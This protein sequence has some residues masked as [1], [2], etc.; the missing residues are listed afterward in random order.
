MK[1]TCAEDI[2]NLTEYQLDVFKDVFATKA[3]FKR[4]EEKVDSLTNA[5][6]SFAKEALKNSQEITAL[7]YRI[8]NLEK[9]LKKVAEKVGVELK[10]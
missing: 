2:K 1:L 4:L 8:G 5:V 10:Y 7:T 9:N 6:D 3:D